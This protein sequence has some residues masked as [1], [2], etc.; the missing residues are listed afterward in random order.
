LSLDSIKALDDGRLPGGKVKFPGDPN[1]RT[2]AQRRASAAA[3]TTGE[4]NMGETNTADP[5]TL[6]DFISWTKDNC[7]A[8]NYM[9]VLSGHS[10][11][12]EDGFLMKD[13]NPPGSMSF[14]GLMSVLRA[15]KDE[16]PAK[17]LGMRIDILGLDSCLMNMAEV[18]YEMQDL[19]TY[20]VGSQGYIPNPG[21]PYR[22]IIG[23]LHEAG[24]LMDPETLSRRIVEEYI[25]HYLENSALGGLSV[26]LCA[27][28]LS[29]SGGVRDAVRG[30][31]E[32]IMPRLKDRAD[33]AFKKD[34]VYAHWA[35]QSYNGE[36]FVDLHDFCKML[37]ESCNDQAVTAACKAVTDSIEE[38]VVISCFCGIDCQH[39]NGLSIYFPWS[40]IFASYGQLL[41]AK[42]SGWGDFLSEYVEAT[43]REPRGGPEE[44][45]TATVERTFKTMAAP[46]ELKLGNRRNPPDGHGPS[47][48]NSMRNPPRKWTSKGFSKCTGGEE[49][50]RKMFQAL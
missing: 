48:M 5:E 37:T 17:G 2:Q 44:D 8:R 6:F 32:V 30:L 15:V 50:L 10:A 24:A 9:L 47:N 20:V 23:A 7:P 29:A 1:P 16:D 25:K 3:T 42:E 45:A 12:V 22:R 14:D 28:D 49:K 39:S 46:F 18:C 11:G 13:E 27:L 36:L 31:V 38:M 33:S 4:L 40:I 35:S 19:A 43:R 26:D 34:I 21:W 41:F